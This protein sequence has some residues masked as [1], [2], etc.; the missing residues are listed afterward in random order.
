MIETHFDSD[1]I[2]LNE[3]ISTDPIFIHAAIV[4]ANYA[5]KMGLKG[6]KLNFIAFD[7]KENKFTWERD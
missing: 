4:L 1:E 2:K 6:E 7:E 3:N 5:N